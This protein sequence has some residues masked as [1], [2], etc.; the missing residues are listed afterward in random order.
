MKRI[1]AVAFVLVLFSSSLLAP[2]EARAARLFEHAIVTAH[3]WVVCM[4]DPYTPCDYEF[5]DLLTESCEFVKSDEDRVECY[6]Y[7]LKEIEAHDQM[8]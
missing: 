5:E 7:I 4:S 6:A 3:L 2:R 8:K 1:A